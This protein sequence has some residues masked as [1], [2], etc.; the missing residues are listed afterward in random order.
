MPLKVIGAG[1]PRTGTM[2]LKH[3]LEQLGFGRCHHMT[4]LARNP[5]RWP[6]WE[7]ALEGG[8]ADWEKIF[9]GFGATV[10]A[11]S[12]FF[13]R[14][15]AE[16]YPDAKVILTVRDPDR[17]FDSMQATVLDAGHREKVTKTPMGGLMAKMWA[18]T[19]R[20]RGISPSGAVSP[21]VAPDRAQAIA[22]FEAHNAE[23]RRAIPA[24]RLLVYEV[25]HG[26]PPL[27]GFLGVPVP[28]A[29]FPRFN[30]TGKWQSILPILGVS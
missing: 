10:D 19:A 26:W 2:S 25:A 20:K 9:H 3:A 22:G 14:D 4:E 1:M 21:G 5:D 8:A 16:R 15:I 24:A 23:V 17:W 30:E 13:V 6:L 11:P 27:C 12:C 29:P 18:Y 28:D 7:R